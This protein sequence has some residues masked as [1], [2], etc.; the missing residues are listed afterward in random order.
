[1]MFLKHSE[2]FAGIIQIPPS[3]HLRIA[4]WLN[5]LGTET[6]EQS[7]G[8]WTCRIR[9]YLLQTLYLIDDI[10]MELVKNGFD[11]LPPSQKEHVDLALEYIHTNYQNDICL[12]VLCNIVNLNRTSLNR[13]FKEK[14]GR[15]AIDY[16]VS[17]RIKIACEAL[18]HTNLKISELAEACGFKYDTYFTKQFSKKMAVSP[19]EYRQN[20]WNR[21]ELKYSRK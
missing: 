15:T 11:D 8:M 12:D 3:M 19:S 6:Y 20:E 17:H 4:E 13:R 5:I 9:R 2:I 7:D 10:Y 16:L 14:T 18:V 1:M 21:K